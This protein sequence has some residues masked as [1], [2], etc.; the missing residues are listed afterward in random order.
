MEVIRTEDLRTLG[1]AQVQALV[2]AGEDEESMARTHTRKHADST[3]TA[4]EM[5]ART[6]ARTRA[7]P[8]A[9]PHAR[10]YARMH[11]CKYAGQ[12]LAD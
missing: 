11:T 12:S 4:H 6:R 2:E 5:D 7:L 3:H 8:P 1:S 9:R 10:V